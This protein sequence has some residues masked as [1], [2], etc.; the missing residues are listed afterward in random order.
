M[1]QTDTIDAIKV[2]HSRDVQH[3]VIEGNK[4]IFGKAERTLVA[5]QVWY[6]IRMDTEEGRILADAAHVLRFGD[7]EG[8]TTTSIKAEQLL[9]RAVTGT[10]HHIKLNKAL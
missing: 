6:A 8:E 3:K 1:A 9:V 7:T 2:R 5:P 4:R 10:D